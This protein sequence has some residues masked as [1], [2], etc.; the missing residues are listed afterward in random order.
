MIVPRNSL[1]LVKL[2]EQAERQI[3][4]IVV[5]SNAEQF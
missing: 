5:P 2:I 1:V 4:N 3:G